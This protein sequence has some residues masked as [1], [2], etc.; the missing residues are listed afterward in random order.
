MIKFDKIKTVLCS[1]K[2]ETLMESI[3]SLLILVL[4]LTAIGVMIRT[5]F[6]MTARLTDDAREWQED[7]A[8][9]VILAPLDE[10][11]GTLVSGTIGVSSQAIGVYFE[12]DMNYTTGGGI[13]VF[14]PEPVPSPTPGP[15][16]DPDPDD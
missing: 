5:S 11:P 4:L 13:A 9:V 14:V 7:F 8:N 6:L 3:V 16:P 15:D 2:G 1:S 10:L 12:F